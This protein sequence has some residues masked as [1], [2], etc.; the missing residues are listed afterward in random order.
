MFRHPEQ[1]ITADGETVGLQIFGDPDGRPVFF[2]H[3]WPGS[4][5]Q[6]ALGDTAARRYRIRFIALDRPG[7]GHTPPSPGYKLADWADTV[8][9]VADAL[10][11]DSF[12]TVG[13]S[14]GGPS[15]LACAWRHPARVKEV[16][17]IGAAPPFSDVGGTG[18][19]MLAFRLLLA[20]R[21]RSPRVARWCIRIAAT[22]I[23]K[24]PSDRLPLLFLPFLPAADRRF[25]R[26]RA[27]A[28]QL[29]EAVR[30]GIRRHPQV[31]LEDADL[32]TAPWGF[33]L[34]GVH[35]PVE[36]W[37][38]TADRT[39]PFVY[40]T[41]TVELLPHARLHGMK[42]EGH[43]SLPWKFADQVMRSLAASDD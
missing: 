43:Y 9:R 8:A 21:G 27:I 1:I 19:L 20:L 5:L 34:S 26:Q 14:G 33:P 23:H 25:V 40:A 38:G 13:L 22:F 41:R 7:Y 10:G 12:D 31:I 18:D 16:R 37:H 3:G 6:G 28:R 2:F 36:W 29:V 32:L 42:D 35:Q 11:I 17:L 39:V 24:F 30:V 4:R 15:A